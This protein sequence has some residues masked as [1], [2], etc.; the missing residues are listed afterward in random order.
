MIEITVRAFL[1]D[2]LLVPVYMEFPSKPGPRFVILRKTDSGREN[3]LESAIFVADSYAE[4]LL[5]AARLNELVK[6][7]MDDLTDLDGVAASEPAGDYP[8]PDTQNKKY[9]YQAVYY[10]TYY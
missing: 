6:T 4:T 1:A 3:R 9:R 5:E 8:A 2:K 7:A 10:I